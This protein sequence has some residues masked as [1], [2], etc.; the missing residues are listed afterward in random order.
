MN[1]W[2]IDPTFSVSAILACAAVIAPVLTAIINNWHNRRMRKMELKHEIYKETVVYQ[3]KLIETYLQKTAKCI[4]TNTDDQTND[5][6]ESFGAVSLYLPDDL[7]ESVIALDKS[8]YEND[9]DA[10]HDKFI[11][12]LPEL[13]TRLQKL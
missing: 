10:A 5:Y 13:T 8:I 3:R 11:Q 4:E 1:S 12:L 7:R 6:A 2:K 9:W